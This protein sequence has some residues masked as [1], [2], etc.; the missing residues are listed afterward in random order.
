MQKQTE[1]ICVRQV[2]E[3]IDRRGC[4]FVDL[5]VVDLYGR[6]RHVTLHRES[7]S[8]EIFEKGVGF[9]AS[10]LGYA[11]VT[12]SDMIL[13]PDAR[14]LFFEKIENE[15]I[16]S[17]ICD[18]YSSENFKPSEHDPRFIFK[19]AIEYISPIADDIKLSIEYEFH[20][21][22]R[23]RYSIQPNLIF[24]ETD[25]P[26]GFWNSS[27]SGEYF[28]G[29]KKGYHR[30]I[31][32]DNFMHLRNAIV[33]ELENVG[34]SV[35]YHHH[36]VGSSQLEIETNFE[37]ALKAA[38]WVMLV[39]HVVR[40]IAKQSG[41]LVTFMPKPLYNEAGNGMHIHQYMIKD[42][43]NI[44]SGDE[45][46][47]LSKTCHQYM[48]GLLKHCPA[49]MAFSNPTTNS[50][51]R[52]VPGFEAPT[53]ASFGLANRNA[54]V[55]IPGYVKDHSE[56]RIEFRTIDASCNPYLAISAMILAGVD[57][58]KKKMKAEESSELSLPIDLSKACDALEEDR[59]FLK[60]IFPDSLIQHWVQT[61]REEYR[62]ISSIP[63]PAEYDLYFDV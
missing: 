60:E 61:K 33:S 45:L 11:S 47:G 27:Q 8:E 62:Y 5:K 26:E 21:F 15:E 51:R 17:F 23:V 37:S 25:S 55:R 56:K 3:E 20:V 57:G 1:V 43:K 48:T 2:I 41:F 36:E 31:P 13:I 29:R 14:T 34:V 18:V 42:G 12:K 35:K 58:I 7:F 9:D 16:A 32:F 52:L 40:K 6:W 24:L 63:H 39:K 46:H 38:D 59:E 49:V 50:Y 30:E 44:F 4:K 22:S 19:K 54:A 53:N 28:V 10:N